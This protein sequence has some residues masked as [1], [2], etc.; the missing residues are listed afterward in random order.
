MVLRS[1]VHA[2]A[3]RPKVFVN[4]QTNAMATPTAKKRRIRSDVWRVS[5]AATNN[6]SKG[7]QTTY[8]RIG[9][10]IQERKGA[11]Q[12][13]S[14]CDEK[15]IEASTN[16]ITDTFTHDRACHAFRR[17]LSRQI[18]IV[19]GTRIHPQHSTIA[20]GSVAQLPS[21]GTNI[22]LHMVYEKKSPIGRIANVFQ[23]VLVSVENPTRSVIDCCS[24]KGIQ[25]HAVT[26]TVRT[27]ANA[28]QRIRF[29]CLIR[30]MDRNRHKANANKINRHDETR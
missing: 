24:R 7:T 30:K 3:Y 25:Y 5:Q 19:N 2:K 11:V 12:T 16:V 21:I 18:P 1:P 20:G 28:R 29:Q 26:S 6:D 14:V 4:A 15:K 8:S 13:R 22:V 27:A 9:N 17:S 23:K 10:C